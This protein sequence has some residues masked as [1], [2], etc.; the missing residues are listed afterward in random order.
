MKKIIASLLIA[1]TFI[2][3][4][5]AQKP[6]NDKNQK[7]H[8]ENEMAM[9]DLNLTP[10]QQQEMKTNKENFKTQLDALNKNEG[11]SVKDAKDKRFA[12]RKE[13]HEKM[14]S[15]LTPEQKNK[16]AQR[17]TEREEDKG[18]KNAK[19]LDKLKMKLNLTDEQVAKIKAGRATAQ[20]KIKSIRDNKQ[21]SRSEMKAQMMAVKEQNKNDM[22]SILTPE[23]ANKWEQMKQEKA[24]KKE[25]KR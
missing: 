21:L 17:K 6:D 10:A 8:H 12:L 19:K 24:D 4:A 7:H 1:G 14:L 3:S 18:E 16:L 9:K 25:A 22:K 23:Q 13:Q 2:L 11:L 20:E 15:I 5:A